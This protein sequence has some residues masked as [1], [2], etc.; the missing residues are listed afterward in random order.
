MKLSKV[1]LDIAKL[2]KL[3]EKRQQDTLMLIPS[4]NYAPSPVREAV[5]SLLSNKYSEGYPGRRYYQG[6][7][8]IDKIEQLAIDRAKKVY[9][10]PFVNVQPYSGSPANSAIYFALLN[11]GDTVMGLKLSGGGHLTHGHPSVTFSGNYFRSVQFDVT[12]DGFIDM[13]QVEALAK[14]EKP[15][16]MMIGTTAY[17]R[18]FD[19]K[20]FRV[21]ADQV[22]AYLVA[23]VSHLS[24]LVAAEVIPSPV[25]YAHVVMLT[26]HKSLGGPRGAIILTTDEGIKKNPLL[27]EA[28]DKAIIP[29]LQGGPHNNVTAGIAVALKLA[30]EKAFKKYAQQILTNAKILSEALIEKGYVLATGGTETHLIVIDFRPQ[31]LTGTVVAEAME[32]AGLVANRNTVPH[33]PNPPFYPSGVRLGTPAVTMRGMKEKEMKK[34]ANWIDEV[35]QIVKP[36]K[37]PEV[38]TERA[39]WV[40]AF[41]KQIHTDKLLLSIAREVKKMCVGFPIP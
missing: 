14:K 8:Y 17:P 39:A 12:E 33:D 38:K 2:I 24:G 23:D 7:K 37:L 10:V 30:Q 1:D 40:A 11:P 41:K 16:L 32:V 28:I 25:P 22:G 20:R 19:W 35:V 21:I 4:E 36:Y 3:E 34:L 27:A 9:H 15:K 26:T 29:G 18:L 31:Q 13:D 5:G 6:N